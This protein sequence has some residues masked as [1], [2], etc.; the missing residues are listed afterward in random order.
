MAAIERTMSS[1]PV[2]DRADAPRHIV[3]YVP[4]LSAGGAERAALNLLEALP[5]SDLRVTLL[6]N[7]REGPLLSTL[8][9]GAAVVRNQRGIAHDQA[10]LRGREVEFFGS[11]LGESGANPLPAF[12]FTGE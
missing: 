9:P 11:N 8:P 10:D 1:A 7:R 12:H 6:L 5:A 3:L 2:A 4:D